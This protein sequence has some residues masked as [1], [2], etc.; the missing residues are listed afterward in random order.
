MVADALTSL[1]AMVALIC[2]HFWDLRWL[3]PG[4]ALV[5]A[6]LIAIWAIG[7]LRESG[8]TLLDAGVDASTREKIKSLLEADADN[9]VSDLHVWRIGGEALS[10][11]VSINTHYP[12]QPDHYRALLEDISEVQHTTIEVIEHTDEPC[13]P[14]K[15][16]KGEKND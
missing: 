15:K 11:A 10:V 9:R 16:A 14:V 13:I 8:S 2:V 5:G 1:L 12:R 3:D 4:V 7:L 6:A